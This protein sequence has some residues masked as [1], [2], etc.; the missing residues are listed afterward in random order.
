MRNLSIAVESDVPRV[1]KEIIKKPANL[2]H[3]RSMLQYAK[4][5]GMDTTSLWVIGSPGE[6]W[7]EIRHTMEVTEDMNSD[8]TKINIVA[9]YPG[10]ELLDMAVAGG[11]L[12]K[13]DDFSK[14]GWGQATIST[15]EFST[16]LLTI[17]RAFEWERINFTSETK[18]KKIAKMIGVLLDELAS[19]RKKDITGRTSRNRQNPGCELDFQEVDSS[20]KCGRHISCGVGMRETST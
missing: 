6:T 11:Y 15:E 12:P 17:L 5:F 14:H 7:D 3:A 2:P 8:F 10:T 16:D 9:P 19:I 1:F 4:E 13:D 20:R 18:R